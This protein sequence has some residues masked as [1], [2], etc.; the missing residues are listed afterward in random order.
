M[1]ACG[2]PDWRNWWWRP[3]QIRW[4][5]SSRNDPAST[6]SS[7]QRAHF[8]RRLAAIE[9]KLVLDEQPSPEE[10]RKVDDALKALWRYQDERLGEQIVTIRRDGLRA[11]AKGCVFLLICMAIS[12]VASNSTILPDIVQSLVSE[13]FIIAG[14][15]ALWLPMELLLY[16][17]WPVSRDRKLY[18][19]IAEMKYSIE[20]PRPA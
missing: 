4:R 6:A 10:R 5:D 12:A 7:M 9:A 2:S 11:L 20:A 1:S 15:V 13:G 3:S 18:R 17:W 14:W 16:E 19:M 8:N